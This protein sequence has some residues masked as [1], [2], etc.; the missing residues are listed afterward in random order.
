MPHVS[1][2]LAFLLAASD[3]PDLRA[4]LERLLDAP[5][6]YPGMRLRELTLDEHRAAIGLELPDA[7]DLDRLPVEVENAYELAV[8]AISAQRPN[9]ARIDLSVAHRGEKLRP[10]K[11]Y[12]LQRPKPGPRY[13][14]VP[15][16]MRFPDGQALLDKTIAIS[17]GHGYIYYDSLGGYSTQRSRVA[18]TG[19]GDCR[20]IV[21]DFE[22]HEIVVRYLI[23]LLEGAG[24]RVVLVRERD[25]NDI[26]LVIDDGETGYSELAGNFFDGSSAGGHGADYRTSSS[27]GGAAEFTLTAQ[28]TGR[29]VLSTWFVPGSNRSGAVEVELTGPFGVID[30]L[31]DQRTHG[32]RWA[33][34]QV[35]DLDLGDDVKVKLTNPANDAMI[36]DAVRLGA[37]LHTSGHRYW[38]MGAFPFAQFQEAPN[39]VLAYGDVTVRPVYAEFYGADVYVALHSNASGATDS[40]AAGLSTYRYNCGTYPDHSA[41][42]PAADCDDPSGSDRLQAAVHA[43]M[44]DQLR[45]DWDPNWVDRGPKVANFGELRELDGI[46]GMLIESA[47]HD[48]VRLASGSS[49]RV[50]DNQALHD[51]RWRRS[52]AYGIY[53]GL[54]EFFGATARLAPPPK[55]LAVKRVSATELS[56][57]FEI[58]DGAV[59][60]RVYTAR[61]GRTFDLGRIVNVPP[62]IIDGLTPEELVHVRVASLN[63]AGEG[64]PGNIVS[65]R[66][67]AKRSQILLVDSFEREDAWIQDLDNRHNTLQHHAAAIAHTGVAFDGATEAAITGGRATFAGYDGT[68]ISLGAESTEHGVLTDLIRL[69]V[70]DFSDNGGAVFISGSELAWALDQR[71]DDVTRAF[72]ADVFGASYGRDDAAVYAVAAAPGGWLSSALMSAGELD[73]GTKEALR[74]RSSDVLNPLAGSTIELVYGTGMEA[75]AVRKNKNLALGF[76]IDSLTDPGARAAILGAFV[77]NAIPMI[78]VD[79]PD[80]GTTPLDADT[81]EEDATV[82]P[83][84]NDVPPPDAGVILP[85]PDAGLDI[86]VKVEEPEGCSCSSAP[87]SSARAWTFVALAALLFAIRSRRR[88]R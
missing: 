49:L 48:Q 72:V 51:P 84:A 1:L 53:A 58:V 3:A 13:S 38:E 68:I 23:P 2:A 12:P 57:D 9:I 65:A 60:Y 61:G 41:D 25:Y 63:A 29:Q 24:A 77:D 59:R 30:L 7:V 64:I 45:A 50:T 22:T 14:V 26:G 31:F 19:C 86:N 32:R 78:P 70:R 16:P 33:P 56:V 73:D 82:H 34:I 17:P 40:T 35:L 76:S 42:P 37:G 83:D 62:A 20:G 8:G 55:E 27:P 43:G 67:S 18:W 44:V 74:A 5:E 69:D 6:H 28:S 80:A 85:P 87:S 66:P 54:S 71:G 15:D 79:P 21:E 88:S 81:M 52:A 75:A 46:P 4:T 10:P 36:T 11:K 47:F 39:E